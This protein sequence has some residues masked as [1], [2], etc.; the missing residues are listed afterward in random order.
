MWSL[1]YFQRYFSLKRNEKTLTVPSVIIN[2]FPLACVASVSVEQRSK[3]R[4]FRSFVCFSLRGELGKERKHF[5]YC[6]SR[7]RRSGSIYEHKNVYRGRNKVHQTDNEG[8][9]SWGSIVKTKH[10]SPTSLAFMRLVPGD[11][12]AV[13]HICIR[14]MSFSFIE[15]E[16]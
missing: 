1:M 7:S 8:R 13:C 15:Q 2:S 16:I 4:G 5:L 14:C 9:L 11:G 10:L 12:R 6:G 3:K